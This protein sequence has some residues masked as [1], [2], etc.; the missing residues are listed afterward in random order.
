MYHHSM[1]SQ[2]WML[3][4]ILL[5]TILTGFSST[6]FAQDTTTL[7]NWW[8]QTRDYNTKY[9]PWIPPATLEEWKQER[10]TLKQRILISQG[11]WPMPPKSP[12]QPVIH[13][14]IE[15]DDYTID[16]VF[17]ASRPGLYVTGNLYRPKNVTGKMPGILS[18]HGHA[19]QGRFTNVPEGTA[20]Q[21]I[22]HGDEVDLTAAKH[23]HQARMVQLARMGCV[24]F[25]YD[26][27]GYADQQ[28]LDHRWDFSTPED[29]LWLIEN[30]GLQTWN[31][32]RSLDFL[33][34]LEGVDP[35]RIGVTGAS[36]GGTQTM[37]LSAI[38]DRVA[39]SVPW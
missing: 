4:L 22:E 30:M 2:H 7:P 21:L 27:I 26:M 10:V 15:E 39:V 14:R 24:V 37:I 19:P 12:L 16:K 3:N 25:H 17:F 1:K 8:R 9:H 36:G 11:L 23:Y 20:K 31:S 18:P 35:N 13:G 5:T 33:L 6:I 29:G 38:D 32:I 34:S 28:P